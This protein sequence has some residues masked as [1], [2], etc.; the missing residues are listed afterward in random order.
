MGR[1]PK[2]EPS[3]GKI[4]AQMGKRSPVALEKYSKGK[5]CVLGGGRLVTW[6][7]RAPAQQTD[8]AGTG[9]KRG[10]GHGK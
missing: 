10:L 7:E 4:R 3:Q 1:A 8:C 5:R 2:L 9:E 6:T